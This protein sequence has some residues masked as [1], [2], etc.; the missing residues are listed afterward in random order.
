MDSVRIYE[1]RKTV[2]GTA[3]ILKDVEIRGPYIEAFDKFI[4]DNKIQGDSSIEDRVF[5]LLLDPIRRSKTPEDDFQGLTPYVLT[6]I[7]ENIPGIN[8]I[9]LDKLREVYRE[10]KNKNPFGKCVETGLAVVEGNPEDVLGN[11]H[12]TEKIGEDLKRRGIDASYGVVL[13]FN[14]L[15]LETDEKNGLVFRIRYDVDEKD[16]KPLLDYSWAKEH[17]TFNNLLRICLEENSQWRASYSDLE[18]PFYHSRAVVVN[19]IEN[20]ENENF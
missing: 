20:L 6:F 9:T 11:S 8:L 2:V 14:Q 12:L 15:K 13:N 7:Q 5:E 3:S 18:Q 19:A 16:I 1:L 10:H 4:K 17:T